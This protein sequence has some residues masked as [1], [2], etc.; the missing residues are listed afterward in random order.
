MGDNRYFAFISYSRTDMKAAAF[1]QSELEHFRYPRES[2]KP[3]K[4][5][6]DP[7]YVREVFLDKTGLSGQGDSFERKLE[8]ALSSSR[9]LI[10]L[11]SPEAARAK[12]DP[13]TKHYVE[14]EIK[15]F[16]RLHGEGAEKRIIP[17]IL[18]GDPDT[19]ESSCLPLP[20]RTPS[21]VGRN[22][23]D[24][25]PE[26]G[27]PT[28]FFGRK[29][30]WHAAIVTLLSYVFDVERSIIFDRFTAERARTRFRIGVAAAGALLV[31]GLIA[32]WGVFEHSRRQDTA[33]MK[34]LVEAMHGFDSSA[35]GEVFRASDQ[36][37]ASLSDAGR[38][39]MAREYLYGQLFQR[40]WIVPIQVDTNT[41][42]YAASFQRAPVAKQVAF[43]VPE[44]FP[45]AFK[46]EE[47]NALDASS[48]S[49][50]SRLSATEVS[51]K[52]VLWSQKVFGL[53]KG[54][55]DPTGVTLMLRRWD[56]TPALLAID[57]FTGR[58]RWRRTMGSPLRDMAFSADGRRLAVLS[59][60]GLVT[61]L[62][63]LDGSIP[64][65][66]YCAGPDASALAFSR[67]GNQLLMRKRGGVLVCNLLQ[68][69]TEL[70]VRPLGASL[71]A[72]D[73]AADNSLVAIASTISD[74]A[75]AL[76]IRNPLTLEVVSRTEFGDGP[77]HLLAFGDN[78]RQVA[79][80]G[81]EAEKFSVFRLDGTNAPAPVCAVSTP[82]RLA[83][84]VA[85]PGG[86]VACESS[87]AQGKTQPRLL[88]WRAEKPEAFQDV[89]PKDLQPVGVV[90]NGAVVR[91]LGSSAV[92]TLDAATMSEIGRFAIP[93]HGESIVC[94]GNGLVAVSTRQWRESFLFQK[95]GKC[96]LRTPSYVAFGVQ[97][98]ALSADGRFFAAAVS[99]KGVQVFNA[100]TGIPTTRVF[101]MPEQVLGMKFVGE[102]DAMRLW[103]CGGPSLT[104]K[105]RHSAFY[106]IIDPAEDN[107][108]QVRSRLS[109]RM[110]DIHVVGA[111]EVLLSG[112]NCKYAYLLPRTRRD[113]DLPQEG[114]AELCRCLAGRETL[115]NGVSVPCAKPLA[116]E[117]PDGVWRSFWEEAKRAPAERH[118]SFDSPI[119]L[120]RCFE[121]LAGGY[122]DDWREE[123]EVGHFGEWDLGLR[124]DPS[125]EQF[126]ASYWIAFSKRILRAR[127]CHQNPEASKR[128][129]DLHFGAVSS[130]KWRQDIFNDAQTRFFC[131]AWTRHLLELHPDGKLA[132]QQREV[133]LNHTEAPKVKAF[134]ADAVRSAWK[135]FCS[136]PDANP[137]N[138]SLVCDAA[139][140]H[141]QDAASFGEFLD[142][143][144]PMLTR[145]LA[146]GDLDH[147]KIFSLVN[148][149]GNEVEIW[150]HVIPGGDARYAQFLQDLLG[151]VRKCRPTTMARILE[152]D[153]LASLAESNL[154]QGNAALA[155]AYVKQATQADA[156]TIQPLAEIYE[157]YLKLCKGEGAEAAR[158]FSAY[159]KGMEKEFGKESTDDMF[160]VLW[161]FLAYL[162]QTGA[163]FGDFTPTF[164][165]LSRQF[166]VGVEIKVLPESEA[167]R[168]GLQNG[169]RLVKMDGVSIIDS[170][171]LMTLLARR[172]LNPTRRTEFTLKRG[173]QFI[174]V[175]SSALTLD[176]VY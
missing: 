134:D 30:S 117:L 6:D 78:C 101:K 142:S 59:P 56:S 121:I 132:R 8:T 146:N 65:V 127:Y 33:A 40:S 61:I 72:L 13:K 104:F 120:A 7:T 118:L 14:W 108:V 3:E 159:Q 155:E 131:D 170:P 91:V 128:E 2:I 36:A 64:F 12:E 103:V 71:M 10:V 154:L 112:L 139:N 68:N 47:L 98:I 75:I 22:L 122:L 114:F 163:P 60:E 69:A 5:P 62:N 136:K 20:L 125:H 133:F 35:D 11:C 157:A 119:P 85:V 167:A 92:V 51:S 145:V 21:F 161:R 43:V 176:F 160:R 169:D 44:K 9:Y 141:S 45:L 79:V 110:A 31:C 84:L 76:E 34:N 55:V 1:I 168:M 19:S 175:G 87:D 144:K 46:L 111:E 153:L 135:E 38:L 32:L 113:G 147:F 66:T 81:G 166:Q 29:R 41:A 172:R 156:A 27:Q 54:E 130:D 48:F 158:L 152:C 28:G 151:V 174:T 102:A 83:G 63:V 88:R 94:G 95:D 105:N 73:V 173:D 143:L 37:L 124:L 23:P 26:S 82:Q 39:P 58:E 25:R 149:L 96:I 15:T 89:T 97:P 126:L 74:R 116:G 137:I 138:N 150:A 18:R 148:F 106:A 171:H 24:M 57:P 123:I 86:F 164:D 17:V 140:A 80:G 53:V 49:S 107:L 129:V 165:A 93:K 70:P 90:R 42:R 67:D 115:D 50:I 4:R 109:D 77:P 99:A 100:E 52:K 162:K 16:L